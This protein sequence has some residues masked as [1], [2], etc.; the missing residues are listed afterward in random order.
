MDL[1]LIMFLE[2]LMKEDKL[3]QAKMEIRICTQQ[4]SQR[5]RVSIRS[6]TNIEISLKERWK[7]RSMD[8]LLITFLE[9]LMKEIKLIQV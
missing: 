8:L 4:L 2:I 5:K 3:I 7:K 9:L 6:I 1:L